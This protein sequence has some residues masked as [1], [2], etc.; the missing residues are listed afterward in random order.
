M[1][2]ISLKLF[3]LVFVA[4]STNLLIAEDRAPEPAQYKV[5]IRLTKLSENG[6]QTVISSSEIIVDAGNTACLQVGSKEQGSVE[7]VNLEL[8]VSES[9]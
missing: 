3:L 2:N 4:L 1:K 9:E 8:R 7:K 5:D 6:L